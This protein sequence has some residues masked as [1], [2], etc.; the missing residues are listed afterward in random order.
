MLKSILFIIV[1]L[2]FSAA[3]QASSSNG[4]PD[5]EKNTLISLQEDLRTLIITTLVPYAKHYGSDF[6][7]DVKLELQPNL[8]TMWHNLKVPPESY[9]ADTKDENGG[10]KYKQ[11]FSTWIN[12]LS[13]LES[14]P[15]FFSKEAISQKNL[16][17]VKKW[18][19]VNIKKFFHIFGF[20]W[21]DGLELFD[22]EM[23]KTTEKLL[24]DYDQ[25]Q[26]PFAEIS[27]RL[28]AIVNTA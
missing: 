15:L 3:S 11:R 12:V 8:E 18:T 17:Y 21:G 2:F 20:V 16:D 27:K 14:M 13:R 22:N 25:K 7:Q 5:Q 6:E 24:H 19:S 1:T 4:L 28:D 10:L 26:D 23:R 9:P